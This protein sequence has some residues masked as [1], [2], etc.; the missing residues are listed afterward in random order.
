V[1]LPQPIRSAD[2]A[3]SCARPQ[4]SATI[5]PAQF[6]TTVQEA[7]AMLQKDAQGK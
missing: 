4:N 7:I 2:R 6:M 1:S 5:F 3:R